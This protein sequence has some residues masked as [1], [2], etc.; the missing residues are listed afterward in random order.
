MY[1]ELRKPGTG[2]GALDQAPLCHRLRVWAST[3]AEQADG[4]QPRSHAYFQSHQK[5]I[6]RIAELQ[7]PQMRL[8]FDGW[9]FAKASVEARQIGCGQPWEFAAVGGL[10]LRPLKPDHV[11]GDALPVVGITRML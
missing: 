7:Q 3:E 5:L 6:D 8:Q 9:I 2:P 1:H 11:E 4:D 10:D